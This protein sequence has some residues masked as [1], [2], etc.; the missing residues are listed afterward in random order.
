MPHMR[1]VDHCPPVKGGGG[2]VLVAVGVL[3]LVLAAVVAWL[4]HHWPLVLAVVVTAGAVAA[5][6]TVGVRELAWRWRVEPW[7]N[8]HPSR[9]VQV[10]VQRRAWPAVAVPRETITGK[11]ERMNR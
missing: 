10:D 5:P 3:V 2:A 1:C 6:V 9:Q 7:S 11:S 8:A 4:T